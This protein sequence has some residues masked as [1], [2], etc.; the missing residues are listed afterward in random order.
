MSNNNGCTSKIP[1]AN[2]AEKN[3][4]DKERIARNSKTNKK[5]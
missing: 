1:E 3:F 2:S 5:F 4:T